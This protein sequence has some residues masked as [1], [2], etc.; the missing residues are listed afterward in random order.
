MPEDNPKTKKPTNEA[1]EAYGSDKDRVLNT[2]NQV[3]STFR[4]QLQT[5]TPNP[6][7]DDGKIAVATFN[8]IVARLRFE[9]L[10][11]KAENLKGTRLSSTQIQLPWTDATV[12]NADG[13]RVERCEGSSCT[14]LDE[15]GRARP[16][17]RAFTDSNLSPNTTYRY[18]VVAFNFRGDAPPSNIIS[19]PPTLTG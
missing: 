9:T 2:L 17:E 4:E 6:F 18:Q 1:L 7:N 13:Y 16:T 11:T 12:G 10:Q 14:D 8:D 19:V 3:F 5:E 15:V